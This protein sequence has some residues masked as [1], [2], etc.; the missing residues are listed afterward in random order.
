MFLSLMRQRQA[1]FTPTMRRF[2]L[3]GVSDL[4]Y[5]SREDVVGATDTKWVGSYAR[6][7]VQSG[8]SSGVYSDA[9]NEYF[10]KN[11]RKLTS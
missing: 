6:A 5:I 11:Y 4:Q 1:F 8:D 10:R 9:L 3:L 7:V 2:G